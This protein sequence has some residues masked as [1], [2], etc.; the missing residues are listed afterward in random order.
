MSTDTDD[1]RGTFFDIGIPLYKRHKNL[2]RLIQSI[3]DTL[4]WPSLAITHFIV[5]ESDA[6]VREALDRYRGKNAFLRVL[7]VK[8]V[9]VTYAQ[10]HNFAF[11]ASRSP[12]YVCGADDVVFRKD[13]AAEAARHFIS[14]GKGCLGTNDAANPHTATGIFSTHPMLTRWYGQAHPVSANEPVFFEGYRHNY[15]DMEF[16]ARAKK[17]GEWTHEPKCVIE[18]RHPRWGTAQ[19]DETYDVGTVTNDADA[20]IYHARAKTFGWKWPL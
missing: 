10:K 14:S 17:L 18:H 2:P 8:D 20:K 9:C 7:V 12:F 16:C 6:E 1:A 4:S 11:R 13:W 15:V 3:E 19:R 5:Q